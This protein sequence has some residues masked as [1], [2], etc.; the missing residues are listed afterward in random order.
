MEAPFNP[1]A[2]RTGGLPDH[3]RKAPLAVRVG[4]IWVTGDPGP[5]SMAGRWG[6][7]VLGSTTEDDSYLRTSAQK[8]EIQVG[9]LWGDSISTLGSLCEVGKYGFHTNQIG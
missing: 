9:Y 5:P 4:D 2:W 6:M 8:L 7:K 3:K 1:A